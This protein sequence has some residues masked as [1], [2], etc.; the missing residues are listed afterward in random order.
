YS[1]T[2]ATTFYGGDAV[3][4]SADGATV[5]VAGSSTGGSLADYVTVAYDAS[6]GAEKWSKRYGDPDRDDIAIAVTR[7]ADG[8][9]LVVTGTSMAS[10]DDSI[11]TVAYNAH[12][13]AKLW[14]TRAGANTGANALAVAPDG[15]TVVVTGHVD[16]AA[17]GEEYFTIAYDA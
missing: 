7:T 6:T 13:G 1:S 2:M 16:G 9:K 5:F 17:A 15:S 10:G 3:V 4:F 8:S 14:S 11:A 12:T